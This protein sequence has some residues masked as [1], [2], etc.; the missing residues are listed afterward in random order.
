MWVKVE[1]P[2]AGGFYEVS[3]L[4]RVRSV[5]TVLGPKAGRRPGYYVRRGKILSPGISKRGYRM[6]AMVDS[7][8][9]YVHVLFAKAFIPNPDNKPF[10]NHKNGIKHDNRVENLEWVT[11][12]ENNRH[13]YQN[14]LKKPR[15]AISLRQAKNVRYKY[16]ILGYTQVKL[17]KEYNIC[18][19]ALRKVLRYQTPYHGA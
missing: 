5:T 7:A 13:A 12:S 19:T 10:L 18:H 17:Q 4:A 8:R 14:G 15:M 6:V 11:K 1:D 3:S 16:E 9:R 2:A